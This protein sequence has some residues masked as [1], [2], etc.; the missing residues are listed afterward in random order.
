MSRI[1]INFNPIL[2]K[3]LAA[4]M[5]SSARVISTWLWYRVWNTED[6]VYFLKHSTK[7]YNK[8]SYQRKIR[9]RKRRYYIKRLDEW[10]YY[11]RKWMQD[12]TILKATK[13]AFK[14]ELNEELKKYK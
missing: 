11:F 3:T 10:L 13:N 14:A 4:M 12:W 6:S 7:R 2:E 9:E 5:D 8:K 1:Y